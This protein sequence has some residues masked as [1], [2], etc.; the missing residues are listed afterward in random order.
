MQ[1][2]S[3]AT[4]LLMSYFAP[5]AAFFSA[6]F[7]LGLNPWTFLAGISLIS[8]ATLFLFLKIKNWEIAWDKLLRHVR[9]VEKIRPKLIT[10]KAP[11]HALL[12]VMQKKPHS[13]VSLIATEAKS[14]LVRTQEE[15][16]TIVN[17]YEKERGLLFDEI[18]EIT[19]RHKKAVEL[20]E[21]KEATCLE[22]QN[23]IRNLQY[24][25]DTLLK[26][27]QTLLLDACSV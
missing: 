11:L 8:T 15:H 18:K 3:L 1:I 16:Q 10:N 13:T 7:C 2:R 4:W 5:F 21:A 26:M 14:D 6:V 25:L 12:P 17:A 24:E 20:L 22:L 27:D 19:A 23:E 9:E